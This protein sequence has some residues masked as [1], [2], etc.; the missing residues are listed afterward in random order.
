VHTIGSPARGKSNE[1]CWSGLADEAFLKVVE[2]EW[3]YHQAGYPCESC[4]DCRA[5]GVLSAGIVVR[6]D[7]KGEYEDCVSEGG[8]STRPPSREIVTRPL[9]VLIQF[10]PAIV[11]LGYR[12]V[13][14]SEGR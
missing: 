5:P 1:D 6:D 10:V 7:V 8:A 3:G 4:E 2:P 11:F 13:N 9:F 14:Y 12:A